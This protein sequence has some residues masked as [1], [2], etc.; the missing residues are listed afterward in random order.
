M[1][2]TSTDP[3]EPRPRCSSEPTITS[4]GSTP[5]M[6]VS[7]TS[8]RLRRRHDPLQCYRYPTPA[9]QAQ[10]NSCASGSAVITQGA[11]HPNVIY[12]NSRRR[13]REVIQGDARNGNQTDFAYSR[14]W[15]TSSPSGPDHERAFE[16]APDPA[17]PT[18]TILYECAI[19][20]SS[21]PAQ[22]SQ[23]AGRHVL[24]AL[25]CWSTSGSTGIRRRPLHQHCFTIA[26]QPRLETNEI[27]PSTPSPV[28]PRRSLVKRVIRYDGLVTTTPTTTTNTTLPGPHRA[29]R[30][31][32][33][34][35]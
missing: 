25:A 12:R 35:P 32:D 20:W 28:R 34:E 4:I 24:H 10:N 17:R 7:R 8:M 27:R 11:T 14:I 29:Y 9:S 22:R 5:G 23:G 19:W 26:R 15:A 30:R 18:R 16:R 6:L 33:T 3:V 31:L 13:L 2:T 1:C 21:K